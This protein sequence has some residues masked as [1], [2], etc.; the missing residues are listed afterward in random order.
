LKNRLVSIIIP[1]FNRV[2]LLARMVDCIVNQTYPFWELIVIDDQSSDQTAG[3]FYNLSSSDHRI[4]FLV[5]DRGPKGAQTCRNIGLNNAHGDYVVFLDSDDLI[6]KNCLRDRVSFMSTN[7]EIDFGVFP[8]KTFYEEPNVDPC[9]LTGRDH[10]YGIKEDEVG[11]TS[12]LLR[13]EY[14]FLVCTN[15]YR[16]DSL[17]SSNLSFDE[18]LG[19]LQDLDFN[20]AAISRGL[21]YSFSPQMDFDYYVRISE[22]SEPVSSNLHSD[23][24][25]DSAKYF[26]A[27]TIELISSTPALST[28]RNDFWGFIIFYFNRIVGDKV[29]SEEFIRY[30]TVFYPAKA[31]RLKLNYLISLPF[32]KRKEFHRIHNAIQYLFFPEYKVKRK[33]EYSRMFNKMREATINNDIVVR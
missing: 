13:G 26:I 4:R 32:K 11:S 19:V 1:T 9:I 20:L 17:T 12:K 28:F 14:P 33:L 18:K 7:L 3:L 21:K 31:F 23:I 10:I 15:M 8:A 6:S 30:C 22:R 25:F 2:S 16:R 29:K 27:K 5:R 24:K